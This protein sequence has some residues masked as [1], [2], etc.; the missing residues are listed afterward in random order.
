MSWKILLIIVLAPSVAWSAPS[1]L[2]TSFEPFGGR[3][4]NLS[5]EV[6]TELIKLMDQA[7]PDWVVSSCILP[8]VYD[9]AAAVAQECLKK[10]DLVDTVISFGEGG[11][12]MRL[13]TAAHNWDQA[14]GFPDNDGNIRSGSPIFLGAPPHLGLR[15]PA[16]Q[17]FCALSEA[18]QSKVLISESPGAFVCNNTAYRLAAGLSNVSL[19]QYGFIHVP[20]KSCGSSANDPAKNAAIILRLIEGAVSFNRTRVPPDYPL[21]HRGSKAKMPVSRVE[22]DHALEK[23]LLPCSRRFLEKLREKVVD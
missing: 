23:N 19:L 15:W 4:Q 20:P 21:P 17:M 8:V 22:I 16:D 2:F 18:D 1:F 6:V 13:E 12:Q 5:Q 10:L 3:S 14:P 9:R 11:C 7:H